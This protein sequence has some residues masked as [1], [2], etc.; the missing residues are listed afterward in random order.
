MNNSVNIFSW[1]KSDELLQL[2]LPNGTVYWLTVDHRHGDVT[3]VT[4]DISLVGKLSLTNVCDGKQSEPIDRSDTFILS[5]SETVIHLCSANQRQRLIFWRIKDG[6]LF[7][8][9]SKSTD[10]TLSYPAI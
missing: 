1:W 2:L 5:Q 10:S 6:D 4:K 9:L 8:S 7:L 3:R